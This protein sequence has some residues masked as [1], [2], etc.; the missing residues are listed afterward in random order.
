[1]NSLPASLDAERAVLGAVLLDGNA[2]GVAALSADDFSHASH[3]RLWRA[4]AALVENGS[5]VDAIT[6]TQ[7][8]LNRGELDAI[9]GVGYL[10]TLTEGVP[11]SSNVLFY[12]AIVREKAM[13]RRLALVG[14]SLY[15]Q[16]IDPCADPPTDLLRRFEDEAADMRR[17]SSGNR[18]FA[19]IADVPTLAGINDGLR[20]E[21]VCET[22]VPRQSITL[23]YGMR[24]TLKSW[25]A[26]DLAVRVATGRPFAMMACQQR[27]VL[28]LDAEMS[29]V[30]LAERKRVLATGEPPGLL[31]WLAAPDQ[32]PPCGI[33]DRRLREWAGDTKGFIIFD[34]LIRFAKCDENKSWEV[35]KV[36]ERFRELTRVEAT[37]LI[38]MHKSDK[39]NSPDYRGSSAWQD[40]ADAG[41]LIERRGATDVVDLTCR[42]TRFGREGAMSLYR[43]VGGF[44]P[45][46]GPVPPGG[47][48]EYA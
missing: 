1:M 44:M 38:L 12:A 31:Y 48:R 2:L 33:S 13:L 14:N 7:E 17:A 41:W 42:R 47:W 10:A 26:L 8:L 11:Q 34:T 27:P 39:P 21:W 5:P 20:V 29:Q 24:S 25:L 28:Y 3:Q 22:F 9:G 18:M 40:A 15:R 6:L 36:M 4:M 43:T 16:A 30:L 45:T 19:S 23:L 35:A 37:V 46:N 32:E